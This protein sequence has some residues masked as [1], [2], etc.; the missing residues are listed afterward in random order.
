M[1]FHQDAGNPDVLILTADD[2]IDSPRSQQ[3]L[4]DLQRALAGGVR[5][6]VVDCSNVGYVSSIAVCTLIR[7]HKRL[8]DRGGELRL[9][10]VQA[11]LHRVLEITRLNHV[12]PTYASVDEAT[13]T[14][15]VRG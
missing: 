10:G 7:L 3:L 11:P 9:T 13:R 1:E 2:Q 12:F 6:L 4:D 14:T 5:T 15:K 8:M